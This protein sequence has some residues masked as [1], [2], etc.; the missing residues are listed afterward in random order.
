MTKPFH[1]SLS[2]FFLMSNGSST[3]QAFSSIFVFTELYRLTRI[4]CASFLLYEIFPNLL[5]RHFHQNCWRSYWMHRNYHVW[6]CLR[7]CDCDT[8]S[9]YFRQIVTLQNYTKQVRCLHHL[10]SFFGGGLGKRF[11]SLYHKCSRDIRKEEHVVSIDTRIRECCLC[12]VKIWSWKIPLSDIFYMNVNLKE[13]RVKVVR[14]CSGKTSF[15]TFCR[16]LNKL[17]KVILVEDSGLQGC[18]TVSFDSL[19]IP[20]CWR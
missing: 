3:N 9:K 20:Q 18:D 14:I 5:L 4:P 8:P 16:K 13:E 7:K 10:S 12:L 15:N 17:R 6:D 2:L 19:W 11:L 1:L